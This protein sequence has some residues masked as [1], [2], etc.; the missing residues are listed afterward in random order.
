MATT[1]TRSYAWGFLKRRVYNPGKL[2]D[3]KHNRLLQAM[4]N[5]IFRKLQKSMWKG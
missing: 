1:V 3:L 5:R 4:T 2:E